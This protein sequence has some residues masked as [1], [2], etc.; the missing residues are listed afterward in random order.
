MQA[1]IRHPET[2]FSG[3]TVG[4][5]PSTGSGSTNPIVVPASSASARAVFAES[6]PASAAACNGP[7][8]HQGRSGS[9]AYR[10]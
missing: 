6:R 7:M 10:T 4:S 5:S 8:P 1:A 9:N 3:A 2:C